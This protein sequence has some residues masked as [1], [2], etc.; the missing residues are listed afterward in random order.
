MEA[1]VEQSYWALV[2]WIQGDLCGLCGVDSSLLRRSDQ[3]FKVER[4]HAHCTYSID[5][6]E[7]NCEG[8]KGAKFGDAAVRCFL[9]VYAYGVF[10]YQGTVPEEQKQKTRKRTRRCC[11]ELRS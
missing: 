6:E 10:V 7:A 2:F 1:E 5:A 11:R 9:L 8:L 4:I 3:Q